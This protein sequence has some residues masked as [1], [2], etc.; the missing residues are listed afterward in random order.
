MTTRTTKP[1]LTG[2][3]RRRILAHLVQ[4]DGAHCFYC[5][6][7]FDEALTGVTLD[8]Y[9]PHC[10]WR[11]NKPRNLRLACHPCNETKADYLP[12]PVA[13]VVLRDAMNTAGMNTPDAYPGTPG[14]AVPARPGTGTHALPCVPDSGT[15]TGTPA[16]GSV[17]GVHAPTVNTD[18]SA[19]R[20]GPGSG[21]HERPMGVEPTVHERPIGSA[22]PAADRSGWGWAA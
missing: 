22:D 9:I 10:I 1:K 14:Y 8:H 13:L 15:P 11:M 16:P 17:E 19:D 18:Q 3:T 12:W 21:V 2:E 4:R 5:R 20:S 6:R 7:P